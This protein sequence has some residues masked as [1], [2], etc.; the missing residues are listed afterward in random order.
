MSCVG[1][2]H[3]HPGTLDHNSRTDWKSDTDHVKVFGPGVYPI[4]TKD[5]NGQKFEF[6]NDGM[7]SSHIIKGF[8]VKL[9]FW[10]MRRNKYF[11]CK[12][13]LVTGDDVTVPI[14]EQYKDSIL[15]SRDTWYELM[16][17][18]N[19][20]NTNLICEDSALI[21]Q[22]SFLKTNYFAVVRFSP[23]P[24]SIWIVDGD[25]KILWEGG[26]NKSLATEIIDALLAYSEERNYQIVSGGSNFS[27]SSGCFQKRSSINI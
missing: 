18:P 17:K 1:Y 21:F 7:F 19:E 11:P 15:A 27:S 24:G 16:L 6:G 10:G 25:K 12:V 22:V 8:G 20:V 13:K 4:L 23:T 2:I 26:Q 9:S 5:W 3:C 14:I